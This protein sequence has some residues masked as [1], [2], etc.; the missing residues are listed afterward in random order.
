MK[1]TSL[2]CIFTL[3]VL[4]VMKA[5][6]QISPGDLAAV[7]AHLEGLSNCTKCHTLGS[8]VSNDKCLDCHKEL[9]EQIERGRGYHSS[10]K[11]R[12][13][14]CVTCHNDHHGRNF[15][16]VKF[17]KETFDHNL[18]GYKL[19]GAHA[20]KDCASCHKPAFI[21]KPEIKKKKFTYLGLSTA[22]KGCHV[23]YH[24]NTLSQ[25]CENCHGNDSFKPAVKFKHATARF[26]LKGRHTNVSCDKC[27]KTSVRNGQ[28]FQEFTGL[29][30]K[31]CTDCHTDPHQ[32]QFG[33]NCSECHT[34]ESFQAT[35]QLS[36]FDHS[37]T[38]FKLEDKHQNLTCRACH[39]NKFTDPVRHEK[40][41]DCHT[42][43]HR[44]Q[45]TRQGVRQDCSD[46]HSPKGFDMNSFTIEKHN[47]SPFKLQGAHIATPC[48]SCHKKEVRWE[49]R[50][51]GKRCADCHQN[52]HEGLISKEY[53]PESECEMCHNVERWSKVSFDHSKTAFQLTGAHSNINCRSCHFVKNAAGQVQQIFAGLSGNCSN[54]HTDHHN[55]QF[56]ANGMTDCKR[57]HETNAW[58]ITNFDHNKTTFRLDGKHENVP[59]AKCHKPFTEQLSTYILYKIRDTR[60]ESCHY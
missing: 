58:L 38:S 26:Q 51:I 23:D 44:G 21:T 19:E 52:I 37:L 47:N 34:V 56:D 57:C 4:L 32:N 13:G 55:K 14:Q 59:C 48:I 24:Q 25:N 8:K 46:C 12:A 50:D 1:L 42:D 29:Q 6:A 16:I 2:A 9:K 5:A 40:C 30:F 3:F 10:V 31:R 28:K 33:Q 35:R 11:V 18:T 15:Q 45:F 41:I 36:K 27:H 7:H 20:K 43:Y 22:C 39:K 60:C 49:F 54:C 53:Y 17:A